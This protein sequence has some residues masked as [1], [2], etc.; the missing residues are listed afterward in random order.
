VGRD[1][2]MFIGLGRGPGRGTGRGGPPALEPGRPPA[3]PGP[4][5]GAWGR[6]AWGRGGPPA[7]APGRGGIMPGCGR[8]PGR[9]APVPPDAGGRGVGRVPIPLAV[10]LKGLLPGR[11]P[12]LGT[13]RGVFPDSGR[14][15][16][17]APEGCWPALPAP[18]S[19]RGP[20]RGP[21]LG[22]GRGPGLRPG[23]G[24]GTAG[25]G[26]SPPADGAEA[27][28]CCCGLGCGLGLGF[29][30]SCPPFAPSVLSLLWLK[31]SLSRRT[32]GASTVEDAE[33]TNSPISWS[34]ARTALLSTPNS[35]ASS[36]TRTFATALLY[37]GPGHEPVPDRR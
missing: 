26:V 1:A 5:R 14:A 2:G 16:P 8:G 17:W 25:R 29:F 21:G 34:L 22:T 3:V 12:G 35:L 13:G 36:Y 7:L 15:G 19:G 30:F 27:L 31:A 33:R 32:T 9:G 11:G 24:L 18:P 10:E 6:G 37:L 20:G 4:G 28:V 23:P